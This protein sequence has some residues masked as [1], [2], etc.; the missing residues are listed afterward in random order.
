MI[1]DMMTITLPTMPAIMYVVFKKSILAMVVGGVG[2]VEVGSV[3]C[4]SCVVGG[5][6]VSG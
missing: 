6:T 2:G 1:T 5:S 4:G 3:V